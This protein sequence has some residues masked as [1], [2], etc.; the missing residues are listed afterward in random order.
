[1]L[2]EIIFIILL[3]IIINASL[4]SENAQSIISPEDYEAGLLLSAESASGQELRECLIK[5]AE[6]KQATGDLSAAADFFERASLAEKGN[7][8]FISLYRAAVLNVEMA[9]YRKAEADLRA[10]LT[11]SDNKQLRIKASVL[12]AR[13]KSLQDN[14][15]DAYSIILNIFQSSDYIPDEAY[16]WGTEFYR[17][18]SSAMDMSELKTRLDA[19]K[20]S[21]N[22]GY[23]DLP[24][25]PTPEIVFGGRSAG[26]EFASEP[27]TSSEAPA[28]ASAAIQIG[29][30]SMKEN[31]EDLV[32][33]VKNYGY[34]AFIKSKLVNDNEYFTVN[35]PVGNQ[36]VQNIIIELKEKGFEGY[37]VY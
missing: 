13:I 29:S 24:H 19:V 10:I 4:L 16:I 3:S 25:I 30:F 9:F 22:N 26:F 6:I 7:K 8:D 31:A 11:F 37:P 2:K 34:S 28:A 12:T 5:L 20:A 14:I 32:K 15:E 18:N 33:T 27:E 35:V 1:M 21:D 36:D 17:H 23:P